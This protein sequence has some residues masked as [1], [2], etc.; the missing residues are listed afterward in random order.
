MDELE[1]RFF[2][3]PGM[4]V[5]AIELLSRYKEVENLPWNQVEE[6]LS[7]LD[8]DE[9][10]IL[11]K[12]IEY[13]KVQQSEL[14][15]LSAEIAFLKQTVKSLSSRQSSTSEILPESAPAQGGSGFEK[16]DDL[17]IDQIADKFIQ[18]KKITLAAGSIT[19]LES[20]LRQFVQIVTEYNKNKAPSISKLSP[21]IIRHYRDVLLKIP[22]HRN[23]IAK[24]ITHVEMTK[25][26]LP[27]ISQ[28]TAKDTCNVVGEFL[29]YCEIEQYPITPGLKSVLSTVK[30]PKSKDTKHRLLFTDDQLKLLFESHDYIQGKFKKP[31]E[32]WTPL[33]ALFT[34]AR[35]GEILQLHLADIKEIDGA[36][37]FDLNEEG[38][39][40][41]KS[42]NSTRIVPVHSQLI[43]MGLLDFV[44]HR[45]KLKKDA[46]L[47]PEEPR[48]AEGKFDNYSKR[49]RTYRNRIGITK[50]DDEMVDFH[51]FRHTIRTKLVEASV[52][53][54][55]IDDIVGHS[56]GGASIGKRVY[57]HSDLIPQKKEA[58]EK[59]TYKIDFSKI[60]PWNKSKMMLL[61]R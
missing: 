11:E 10:T 48:T 1:K 21:P 51:S 16:E 30:K 50:D 22:K 33:I 6:L 61:L 31:S 43:T 23:G 17:P 5:K 13:K 24:T 8:D 52:S 4:Y 60:K 58:I 15:R 14:K 56:S 9:S 20:K 34:G 2:S 38:D 35:M 18:Y 27:P 12:A 53:E 28:K 29:N 36:W 54:T 47:F 42:E 46:K 3:S 25:M 41:L 19:S 45:R 44:A 26:G 37:V 32:F 49:F 39:K 55:L 7:T 40:Q 57:T 59:L